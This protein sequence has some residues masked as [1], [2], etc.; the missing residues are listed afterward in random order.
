M[1]VL[2]TVIAIA[3]VVVLIIKFKID[4]V[5]SLVIGSIY[6]GLAGGV[7]FPGTIEAI[8]KGFGSI[9]S[10]VGLLIGF[11]VLIGSLLHTTGAFTKLVRSLLRIF[12]PKRIP[13]GLALALA[14]ILPSIYVDVQV[15]L[16]APVARQASKHMGPN[17][18]ALMAG[19][20][21]IGI[22]SGYVFVVPGLSAI[23]IA[24]LMGIPLGKYLLF[25]IVVGPL[26]ALLT[27]ILFQQ[28][29][30][31]GWWKPA[32]D[33]EENEALLE[34]EARAVAA[35]AAEGSDAGVKTPPLAI[36]LLP[37]VVPLVMIAFG[38]FAELFKVTNQFIDFLG[39]ANIALFVGLLMAFA[40]SLRTVG[41]KAANEAFS[42]GLQTSGEILLVTG[43]GGSL[44][45]VIKATGLAKVLA[46]MF[47]AD[48]GAPVL[49][50]ILLAWFVAALLHLAIGSVSVAAITAA[51]IIAP[52][53]G[54]MDVNPVAVG[55]AIASGSLFALHVNSNFF[56][57]F[58]ALLG[59]STQGSLKTMTTVTTIGS[60][61]SL[62][63]VIGIGLVA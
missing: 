37:I 23:S 57:M 5:I 41:A 15:V 24:G 61:I 16:A 25:G 21:G 47:D 3:A 51:G 27:V 53:L 18:L 50:S 62:P 7:G 4:P 58:K 32:K 30:R 31:F 45:A 29:L 14:T 13:Y 10:S 38:A 49:L 17:G 63:M 43:I 35:E 19:A 26:T 2:H 60:L 20:L 28:L 8:T 48:A 6:L 22:F 1:L 36:S 34:S 46:G 40:L 42:D 56:W 33:E 9:M 39:N 55:L 54:Q 12:G 52:L 59:L 44:G 11:G